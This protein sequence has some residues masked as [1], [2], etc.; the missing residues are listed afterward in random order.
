MDGGVPL[1]A[2]ERAA[3]KLAQLQASG[4]HVSVGPLALQDAELVDSLW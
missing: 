4:A 2:L 3:A 1:H